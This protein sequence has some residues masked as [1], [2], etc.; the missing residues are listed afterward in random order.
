MRT[1]EEIQQDYIN[2]LRLLQPELIVWWKK[3]ARL[4]ELADPVPAEVANRW[5]TGY[6]GHPRVLAVF[7]KYYLEIDDL[8]QDALEAA[9]EPPPQKHPEELWGTNDNGDPIGYRQ[10]LDLLI[11]DIKA[12]APDLHKLVAGIVYVPIGLNQFE[13]AV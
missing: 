12:A 3:L 4:N 9:Q 13:E 2:E 8:N 11:L 1:F 6:S 5:P 10:P 7:R